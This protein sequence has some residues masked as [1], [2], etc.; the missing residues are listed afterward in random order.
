MRW[1]RYGLNFLVRHIPHMLNWIEIWGIFRP[2]KH[3]EFFIIFLKPLLNNVCSV[4]GVLS[5]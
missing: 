1:R 4:A 2:G 3:L 5:C